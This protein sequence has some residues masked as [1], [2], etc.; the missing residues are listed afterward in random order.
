MKNKSNLRVQYYS[1]SY[2]DKMA[3]KD[4]EKNSR[5]KCRDLD[6]VKACRGSVLKDK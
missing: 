2:E 6:R 3:S 4:L 1:N 5:K